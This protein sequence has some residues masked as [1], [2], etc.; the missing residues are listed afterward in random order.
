M[1][2]FH[3]MTTN[4][5]RV[6]QNHSRIS[7]SDIFITLVLFWLTRWPSYT[8]ALFLC[9]CDVGADPVL[10]PR[11]SAD[12]NLH[13]NGAAWCVDRSPSS[14]DCC[15]HQV[16]ISSYVFHFSLVDRFIDRLTGEPQRSHKSM[17]HKSL[18]PLSNLFTTACRSI[19]L[20][21][22]QFQSGWFWVWHRLGSWLVN[23]RS[24]QSCM[25][26]RA[27]SRPAG[28]IGRIWIYIICH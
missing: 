18:T 3:W 11:L 6:E 4:T 8:T 24:K 16:C 1:P 15:S 13:R 23:R 5:Q 2:T 25:R 17:S 7:S 21:L 28:C 27:P 20:E 26:A 9:P 19:L 22:F 14:C 10:T 12:L